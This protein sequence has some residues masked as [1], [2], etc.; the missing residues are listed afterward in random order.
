MSIT[1][2]I[3]TLLWPWSILY[4][5]CGD[6][7]RFLLSSQNLGPRSDWGWWTWWNPFPHDGGD[8]G[9]NGDGCDDDKNYGSDDNDNDDGGD[10][11]DN[12]D[13]NDD[14]DDANWESI[15]LLTQL[16]LL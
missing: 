7:A 14:D 11:G 10:D 1:A 6:F 16:Q 9:D 5:G 3:S 8:G 4:Q 2:I 13:D 12:D 15:S